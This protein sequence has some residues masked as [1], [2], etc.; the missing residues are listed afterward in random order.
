MQQII[1]NLDNAADLRSHYVKHVLQI[2]DVPHLTGETHDASWKSETFD[3]A[4]VNGYRETKFYNFVPFPVFKRSELGIEGEHADKQLTIDSNDIWQKERKRIL[5]DS[6]TNQSAAA[7]LLAKLDKAVEDWVIADMNKY[8]DFA[9]ERANATVNYDLNSGCEP[10]DIAKEVLNGKTAGW[11]ST[12]GK[13]HNPTQKKLGIYKREGDAYKMVVITIGAPGATPNTCY[14]FD[15]TSTTRYNNLPD[16]ISK[17]IG[18][19][20]STFRKCDDEATDYA[21]SYFALD[22]GKVVEKEEVFH[23][24]NLIKGV[25]T[26][27][28][29]A[30][31]AA[32][33]AYA[34]MGDAAFEV[35]QRDRFG[36]TV[37]TNIHSKKNVCKK[38]KIE[39]L[40]L[41]GQHGPSLMGCA[42]YNDCVLR[43]ERF[44]RMTTAMHSHDYDHIIDALCR[45]NE[46]W[47]STVCDKNTDANATTDMRAVITALK[48]HGWDCCENS[49]NATIEEALASHKFYIKSLSKD[50]VNVGCSYIEWGGRRYYDTAEIRRLKNAIYTA[51]ESGA[52]AKGLF[53]SDAPLDERVV[54][55]YC[56][57]YI[58]WGMLLKCP[59]ASPLFIPLA[60][61]ANFMGY[62]MD[63]ES[64]EASY[65]ELTGLRDRKK[66]GEDVKVESLSEGI[67]PL[68]GKQRL[69]E[70]NRQYLLQKS[71]NAK[72]YKDMS[73]GKTRYE[74]RMKSKI[75]AT[76]RDYNNIEMD[77]LFKRDIFEIKIP[78]MGETD[79]Y[80]VHVRID[81]ILK[82]VHKQLQ[83]NNGVLEFK[84]ILQALMITLNS[85]DVYIGCTCPDFKYRQRYW[86]TKNN[87]VAGGKELRPSDKTNPNDEL[88]AACKHGLLILANLDWCVKVASVINNYIK[89]CQDHLEQAYADYIFPKIYGIKYDKAVQMSLFYNGFLPQD[90]AT[91]DEIMQ[92]SLAGRNPQGKFVSDN[93]YE[94]KKNELSNTSADDPNQLK[95]NI[96][97]P[98][99]SIS[100]G[101]SEGE[102]SDASDL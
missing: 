18:E 3:N 94:F 23:G 86:A 51:K 28:V 34:S 67:V 33:D 102:P 64:I 6:H 10:D 73:N 29:D 71:R 78:V 1:E 16:R 62:D 57:D 74:R 49:L 84:T 22:N 76:I 24:N 82:E 92:K 81:G 52:F 79:V 27:C 7:E 93:P 61:R 17:L 47:M 39:N 72:H 13:D 97:A 11:V 15:T 25:S 88:G 26:G 89:Y 91:H 59:A 45:T 5:R 31:R 75:S 66:A 95:L 12:T 58:G 8:R 42:T 46:E 101:N 83:R 98:E 40:L 20:L 21:V 37:F 68:C 56:N 36:N 38:E 32:L 14:L 55:D 35:T 19:D 69:T 30:K 41:G 9:Y 80:E 50:D 48:Q 70:A 60:R 99:K 87:Y 2:F 4:Y 43:L 44:N 63:K 54:L 90:K 65:A 53:K 96:D 85:G 77:Q 100:L